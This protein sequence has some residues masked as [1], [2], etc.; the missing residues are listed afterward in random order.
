LFV[1]SIIQLTVAAFLICYNFRPHRLHAVHKCSLLL[2]MSHIAWSV[3][4]CS[5]LPVCETK[6]SATAEGPHDVLC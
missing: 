5:Q 4:L 6:S 1:I 3:C 2:Q